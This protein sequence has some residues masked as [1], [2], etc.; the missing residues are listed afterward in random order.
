MLIRKALPADLDALMPIFDE[1]RG[2]IGRLGIDQWQDGYPQREVIEGDIRE[3]HTRVIE[4]EGIVRGTFALFFDGEPTYDIIENGHWLTG[5]ENRSYLAVH[6]V[7]IAVASR[8]TGLSAALIVHAEKEARA[9][10]K[11]SIRIDTHEGNVVMRRM[12]E[13]NG[14]QYCG[15]IRLANGDPRVAYEKTV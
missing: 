2:T 14:L 13:K 6:R 5:D 11:L 12:L 8:G 9:A 4:T 1:A 10:G 15:V 7:A 3:G